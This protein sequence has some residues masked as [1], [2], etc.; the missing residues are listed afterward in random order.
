MVEILLA[1]GTVIMTSFIYCSLVV[2]KKA[3]EKEFIEEEKLNWK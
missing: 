2:A 1:S 3:D